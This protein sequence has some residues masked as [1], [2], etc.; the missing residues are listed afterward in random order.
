MNRTTV[1]GYLLDYPVLYWYDNDGENCLSMVPLINVKVT[2]EFGGDDLKVKDH[3][4]WSFSYPDCFQQTLSSRTS[5][6]FLEIKRRV[7]RQ[8]LFKSVK[9]HEEKV[10]LPAVAM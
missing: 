8:P 1:F 10:T 3:L 6:W 5:T 7:E 4:A 2:A 9:F